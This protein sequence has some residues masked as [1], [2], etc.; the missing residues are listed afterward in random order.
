L[1]CACL[2]FFCLGCSSKEDKLYYVA[3]TVITGTIREMKSPGFWIARHPFA[4]R[5]ILD[6]PKIDSFNKNTEKVLK[7]TQDVVDLGRTYPGKKIF[8]DLKKS[9]DSFNSKRY[10]FRSGI[11]ADKKF[12]SSLEKNMS[13]GSISLDTELRYGLIVNYADQR[14]LPSDEGLYE[15]PGDVNFDELQNNSLDIGTPLAI[16]HESSDGVW[17]YTLG[18]SSGGWV[19][20]NKISFLTIEKLKDYLSQPDF[21]VV[22]D[23]KADIFLDPGLTLYHDY[24][25]MGARFPAGRLADPAAVEVFIPSRLADGS[26]ALKSAYIKRESVNF[27]YL[28]YTPRNIID[29]AFKLINTPYGWGGMNGEQDCSQFLQEIFATVGIHL[30]RNSS[31]QAQVGALLAK[32]DERSSD[33]EKVKVLSEKGDG[34]ITLI[35]LDNHIML[36]LG[37]YNGKPYAIHSTWAFRKRDWGIDNARVINRVAVTGMDL[38]GGTSRGSLLKRVISINMICVKEN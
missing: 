22:T 19:K 17:L 14:V 29:R 15:E 18:P 13:L 37:M 10:Y 34:G 25:R 11:R 1:C 3:P 2:I 9:L 35:R 12:Y 36:F 26:M 27:G 28:A 38:G 5:V 4:D 23:Q 20:K 32:F 7:L 16:L 6:G 24:V 30:P 31:A 8:D 33:E 21:C